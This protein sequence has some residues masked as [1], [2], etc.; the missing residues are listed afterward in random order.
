MLAQT[1]G[2]V[3]LSAIGATVAI[4]VLTSGVLAASAVA[5]AATVAWGVLTAAV[6]AF[7]AVAGL[8]MSPI[9]LI[10]AGIAVAVLAVGGLVVAFATLTESGQAMTS[11]ILTMFGNIWSRVTQTMGGIFDAIATGNLGLAGEIAM[12]SL[13]LAWTAGW[14]NIKTVSM[15]AIAAIGGLLVDGVAFAIGLTAT[16]IDLLIMAWNKLAEVVDGTKIDFSAKSLVEGAAD[17]AKAALDD[18]AKATADE[19]RQGVADAG[20]ALDKLT[21]QAQDAKKKRDADF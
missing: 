21:K 6:G 8:A 10:V 12:A 2:I 3:V 19:V 5:T 18:A 16:K 7:S 17:A 1:I 14:G 4:A 15:Q 13:A 20:A 9:G 11:A